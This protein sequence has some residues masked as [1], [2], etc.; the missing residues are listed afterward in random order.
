MRRRAFTAIIAPVVASLL[1]LSTACG[2]DEPKNDS[3]ETKTVDGVTV[4]LD[5]SKKPKVDFDEPFEVEKTTS[6]VLKEGKGPKVALGEQVVLQYVGIN[7][8]DGKEFDSSW[9]RGKEAVFPLV[10]GSLIKGFIDGL[11]GKKAGSRVLLTIT[12]E[13]GY[14]PSGGTQDGTIKKDDSLVF[15]VDLK[16]S[17]KP[18][19]QAKG[20]KVTPAEGTPTVT[21]DDKDRP[22]GVQVPKGDPPKK[23]VVQPLV[24][25]DG[26]KV[27]DD[28]SATAHIL[29]ATW[30]TGKPFESTWDRGQPQTMPPLAQLPVKGLADGLRNQTVGSR[31]LLVI[32]PDQ[33]FQQDGG[34]GV[35]LKKDD[36][37]IL[38]VDILDAY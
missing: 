9:K 34:E 14:G 20:E 30:R 32:P 17:Y 27:S 24:K 2:S 6:T 33:G 35:D 7:G 28:L 3:S 4:S 12:P 16:K 1:V 38:V 36:T 5:Q 11:K 18:L 19:T 13:D 10:E 25:G 37:V 29:G 22:T 31:V 21:L 26:K 15:V 8:R 23:L